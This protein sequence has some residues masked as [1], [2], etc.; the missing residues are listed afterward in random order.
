[1]KVLILGSYD[2]VTKTVMKNLIGTIK[3]IYDP[4]FE[5]KLIALLVES[6]RI[7]QSRSYVHSYVIIT[8]ESGRKRIVN[9]SINDRV[10]DV[11]KADETEY[12]KLLQEIEQE[13]ATSHEFRELSATS[14]VRALCHWADLILIVKHK[15]LTRGGELIELAILACMKIFNIADYSS[16]IL[17]LRKNRVRLSW[18]ALEMLGL[19]GMRLA[20]KY[21]DFTTLTK[22][23]VK[24][25]DLILEREGLKTPL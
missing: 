25:I 17:L 22:K 12:V 16:K 2:K 7:F 14:K 9:L 5:G 8:E 10:I 3:G 11:V 18:M 19:G 24:E 13:I 4:G 15:S 6:V 20:K 23:V 1:M 21:A